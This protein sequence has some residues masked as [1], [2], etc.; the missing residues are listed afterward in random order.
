VACA[1]LD[2][3][4]VVERGAPVCSAGVLPRLT[5][6]RADVD[7]VVLTPLAA[8]ALL[9]VL[10]GGV[11]VGPEPPV[12][13]PAS[14]HA[15]TPAAA[16]RASTESTLTHGASRRAPPRS[17]RAPWRE[18]IGPGGY[19]EIPEMKEL[20]VAGRGGGIGGQQP[21]IQQL[22][23]QAQRMQQ[24]LEAAQAEL[25]GTEVQGSAGGG[26]VTATLLAS[27]EL[28]ALAIDPKVVDPE[29]VETLQD[30]IVAAVRDA[31]RAA[32]ELTAEKM[33]PLTSGLGGAGLGGLGL[34]G[35]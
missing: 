14:A 16:R 15:S 28:Q 6:G 17:G 25:A 8:P 5:V 26:L 33:G 30:L 21:N 12:V 10:G 1:V 7:A 34:P 20:L 13:H 24:Q 27:G 23:K 11:D 2:A 32:S 35:L 31:S 3:A 18:L 19:P 9:T 29:D 22:M 4:G